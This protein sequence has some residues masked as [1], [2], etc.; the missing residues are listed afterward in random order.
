MGATLNGLST[1][2]ALGAENILRIEFDGHQNTN[3]A[4]WYMFMAANATFCLSLDLICSIF[5]ACIIFFYIF[6]ESEF[7]GEKVGL[8][9][10]Q[11]M[12]LAG[13]LQFGVRQSAEVSNQMTAVER[14][15]EY[16]QLEPEHQPDEPIKV[17]DDWP[18]RGTVEFRKVSYRYSK[19]ADPVLQELTFTIAPTEK[20][21][22]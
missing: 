3:T 5:L 15:L 2:R 1:V 17:S 6:T 9:I 11:A 12:S 8:V 7:S 20:I 14:L 18:N 10:T 16:Q 4:C 13:I 21:G 19:E 22:M